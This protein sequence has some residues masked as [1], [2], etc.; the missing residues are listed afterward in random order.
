MPDRP[1][2]R[3]R[4]EDDPADP[5]YVPP[6]RAN[7]V[8]IKIEIPHTVTT[9]RDATNFVQSTQTFMDLVEEGYKF[10]RVLAAKSGSMQSTVQKVQA[11]ATACERGSHLYP[12][13]VPANESGRVMIVAIDFCGKAAYIVYAG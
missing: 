9:V 7:K 12:T 10:I 6:R 3:Q 11:A 8:P 2:R 4:V 13:G 1:A 5:L